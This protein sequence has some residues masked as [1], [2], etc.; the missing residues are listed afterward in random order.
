[1]KYWEIVADKLSAASWSWSYCS[2]VTRDGWRWIV[3]A[4]RDDGRRVSCDENSTD[5]NNYSVRAAAACA[6]LL[7]TPAASNSTAK[8]SAAQPVENPSGT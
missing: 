7:R 2:A 6:R 4:H 8:G 3:D 5:C 1:M